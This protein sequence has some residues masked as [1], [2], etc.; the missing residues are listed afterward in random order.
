MEEARGLEIFAEAM[1]RV[2]EYQLV[3]C[4]PYFPVGALTEA[5]Q[6]RLH[7][8]EVLG[9]MERWDDHER[10]LAMAIFKGRNVMKGDGVP[11]EDAERILN[12]VLKALPHYLR[13]PRSRRTSGTAPSSSRSA[14]RACSRSWSASPASASRCSTRTSRRTPAGPSSSAT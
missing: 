4:Y 6:Y 13:R 3:M 14:A 9:A 11:R 10:E 7:V 2:R 8:L 12:E 5:R 1:K